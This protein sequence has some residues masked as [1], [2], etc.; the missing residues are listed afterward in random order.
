MMEMTLM[1]TKTDYDDV[2]GLLQG[3]DRCSSSSF[4]EECSGPAKQILGVDA[5]SSLNP[6]CC[7]R[8]A[9]MLHEV[10]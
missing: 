3:Y 6:T 4:L 10:A 5:T 9:A 8:L 7:A 2:K 1:T